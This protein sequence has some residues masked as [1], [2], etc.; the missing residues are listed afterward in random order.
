MASPAPENDFL[1]MVRGC[2]IQYLTQISLALLAGVVLRWIFL[3]AAFDASVPTAVAA[4]TL[5]VLLPE[6]LIG[7]ISDGRLASPVGNQIYC[8][9]IGKRVVKGELPNGLM[10]WYEEKKLPIGRKPVWSP[11]ERDFI[12][13]GTLRHFASGLL[14]SAMAALFT[15]QMGRP[16]QTSLIFLIP[17]EAVHQLIRAYL[18][19]NHKLF[20]PAGQ[21]EEFDALLAWERGEWAKRTKAKKGLYR[22]LLVFDNALQAETPLEDID[23]LRML[24][25]KAQASTHT[26]ESGGPGGV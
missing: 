6:L 11:S 16:F 7:P 17:F 1:Q 9:K 26:E 5:I 2:L 8:Q 3:A 4:W 23:R 14:F 10:V 21:H 18:N 25:E 22:R 12:V 15:Q 13:I 20:A 19:L 24:R